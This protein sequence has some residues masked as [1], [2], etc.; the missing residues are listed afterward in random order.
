MF[1]TISHF[2]STLGVSVYVPVCE[3]THTCTKGANERAQIRIHKLREE[4]RL[5]KKRQ[6]KALQR[7]LTRTPMVLS[8]YMPVYGLY[9]TPVPVRLCRTQE[10][11]HLQVCVCA[12]SLQLC[13]TLRDPMDCIS[14]T[15]GEFFTSEPLGK[16]IC[17]C[18]K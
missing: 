14:C 17:K 12:G 11:S 5:G 18:E 10:T 6:L 2:L 13:L 15:A 3:S 4:K 1:P 16:P 9:R 8:D 7:S